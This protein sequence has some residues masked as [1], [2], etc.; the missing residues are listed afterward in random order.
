MGTD[1]CEI[2]T[3]TVGQ[4][5][6]DEAPDPVS[7]LI[8]CQMKFGLKINNSTFAL[9]GLNYFGFLIILVLC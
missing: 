7:L 1:N 3:F 2:D 6:L 9:D 4:I 5:Y 8:R